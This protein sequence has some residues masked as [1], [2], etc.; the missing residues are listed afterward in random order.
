M[1]SLFNHVSILC[2]DGEAGDAGATGNT[3]PTGNV[4]P[5]VTP[6]PGNDDKK[7]TQAEVNKFLAEDKRKHKEQYSALEGS[8]KELLTNQ[9][10]TTEERDGLQARLED[11][12]KANRTKEQQAEF[13]RKAAEEKYKGELKEARERADKWE[14][15][16]KQETVT[17][18]LQDAAGGADAYN[19]SQVVGLLQ[20]MTSLKDVEGVLT[21]M[22]DFQDIDEKTG[23]PVTTLRTPADA[24][25]R[26]QELPKIHGNLFR[27]NVVSG[28]GA[29]QA[30]V[31]NAGDV[32]Y[33]NMSADEYRK[34]R[35]AIKRRL[36]R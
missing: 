5:P 22:V 20:P 1:N 12:Q 14:T 2:F 3:A 33:S 9:N 34:N 31:S 26:M 8:Y 6:A 13:E 21:P 23:E 35:E 25:K 36:Q 7:F 24:V 27:S 4:T 16:F 10:L 28:V 32:D 30:N 17:R 18:S 19:P 11:V 15:M 29:G